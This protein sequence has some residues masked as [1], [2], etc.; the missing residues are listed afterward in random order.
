MHQTEQKAPEAEGEREGEERGEE[1]REEEAARDEQQ[2]RNNDRKDN[3]MVQYLRKYCKIPKEK[4]HKKG[5][6]HKK[7]DKKAQKTHTK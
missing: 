5:Q 3:E 6:M 7:T 1:K 4:E 2:K